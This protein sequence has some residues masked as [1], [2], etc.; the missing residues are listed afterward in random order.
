MWKNEKEWER[1]IS[2]RKYE[3]RWKGIQMCAKNWE[4]WESVLKIKSVLESVMNV[5]KVSLKLRKWAK[6]WESVPKIEKVC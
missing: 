2:M 1:V 3:I 5:K 4:M 6:S